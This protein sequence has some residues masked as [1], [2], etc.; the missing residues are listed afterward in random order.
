M[1][2]GPDWCTGRRLPTP[3][4][5]PRTSSLPGAAADCSVGGRAWLRCVVGDC[6]VGLAAGCSHGSLL[7]LLLCPPFLRRRWVS[8]PIDSRWPRL[9]RLP[10][11]Y[12]Y[13]DCVE[14]L[15]TDF[16]QDSVLY[17]EV[18][19]FVI[20]FGGVAGAGK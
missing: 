10:H 16:V 17:Q 19:L 3:P 9:P 13:C 7:I 8:I 20:E 15:I 14:F 18:K 6:W 11:R 1:W 2:A 5:L 12:L 4:S